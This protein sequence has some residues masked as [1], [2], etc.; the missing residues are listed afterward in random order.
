MPDFIGSKAAIRAVMA[1]ERAG[2][3]KSEAL[4]V[5]HREVEREEREGPASPRPPSPT[6]SRGR[7][8]AALTYDEL[9][10]ARN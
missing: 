9:L 1:A 8:I 4:D 6:P 7:Q 5:F 10:A 3:D 2:E